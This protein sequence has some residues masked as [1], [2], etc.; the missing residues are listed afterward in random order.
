MVGV[1]DAKAGTAKVYVNGELEGTED[2]DAKK[3]ARDFE[4]ATWKIG[5]A[6][7]D[8]EEWSWPAKGAIDDVRLYSRALSVEEIQAIH[9]AG[10]AGKGK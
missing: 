9:K 8:S 7:P 2:F 3:A 1:V 4:G 5:I 10:A 6:E